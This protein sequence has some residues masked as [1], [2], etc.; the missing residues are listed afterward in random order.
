MKFFAAILLT[1]ATSSALATTSSKN[2]NAVLIEGRQG[3]V[4]L[5]V[6]GDAADRLMDQMSDDLM[7]T[8]DASETMTGSRLTIKTGKDIYCERTSGSSATCSIEVND[9]LNGKISK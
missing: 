7:Q 6:K 9:S 4:I 5:E 2:S 3:L 8:I 1:V